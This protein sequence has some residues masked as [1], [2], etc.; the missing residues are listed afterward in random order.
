MTASS[1]L[2]QLFS[3]FGSYFKEAGAFDLSARVR[4][5]NR[6]LRPRGRPDE[7]E[8]LSALDDGTRRPSPSLGPG[9]LARAPLD[10]RRPCCVRA[11]AEVFALEVSCARGPFKSLSTSHRRQL[12][13]ARPAVPACIALAVLDPARVRPIARPCALR[14]SHA[15][16]GL[17]SCL[18]LCVRRQRRWRDGPAG[19][20][21]RRRSSLPRSMAP[22]CSR[23]LARS[24]SAPCSCSP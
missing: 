10:R 2:C 1:H 6:A 11:R 15:A 20:P 22:M 12:K 23:S 13:C 21:R 7:R 4:S 3:L 17:T 14:V 5:A 8:R 24:S 16:A 18:C 9:L 19:R